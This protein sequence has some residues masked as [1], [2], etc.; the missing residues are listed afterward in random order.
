MIEEEES[1]KRITSYEVAISQHQHPSHQ[2]A[3]KAYI[4]LIRLKNY[5]Y[6]TLKNY[7]NWFILFLKSMRLKFYKQSAEKIC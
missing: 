1:N 2:L 5:S 4:E 7:K 3:L 6:H